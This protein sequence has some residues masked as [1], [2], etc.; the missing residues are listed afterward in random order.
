M[1]SSLLDS[2]S[3]GHW[4]NHTSVLLGIVIALA[5]TSFCCVCYLITTKTQGSC[6]MLKA[7]SP[8]RKGKECALL[9]WQQVR[10]IKFVNSWMKL[11]LDS[12][13]LFCV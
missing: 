5:V 10:L 2:S 6:F 4:F 3:A 8:D 7:A 11:S 9:G 12:V 1:W 13:L